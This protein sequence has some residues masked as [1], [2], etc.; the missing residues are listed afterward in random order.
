MLNW[1]VLS[2]TASKGQ[3]GYKSEFQIIVDPQTVGELIDKKWWVE[4][5]VKIKADMDKAE[6]SGNKNGPYYKTYKIM[7]K[8]MQ[9]KW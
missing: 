6:S 2:K 4:K 9:S 7:K 3:K 5:V 1:K 8:H